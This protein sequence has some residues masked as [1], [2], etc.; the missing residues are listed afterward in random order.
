[1]TQLIGTAS[2]LLGLALLLTRIG[3]DCKCR[4][5]CSHKFERGFVLVAFLLRKMLAVNAVADLKGVLLFD[6]HM[7]DP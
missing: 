1:M 3:K 2:D 7:L 5:V 4:R 6:K